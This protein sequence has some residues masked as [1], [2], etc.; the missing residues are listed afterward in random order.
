MLDFKSD[1]TVEDLCGRAVVK[2]YLTTVARF[3]PLKVTLAIF[4]C[5]GIKT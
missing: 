2:E 1:G 3:L 5:T 4:Y